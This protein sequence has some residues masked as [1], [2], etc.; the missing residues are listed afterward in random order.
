MGASQ[1]RCCGTLTDK[2]HQF[3]LASE[4]RQLYTACDAEAVG[5]DQ[6]P[7]PPD[8]IMPPQS[9]AYTTADGMLAGS[10]RPHA[11][12]ACC[13]HGSVDERFMPDSSARKEGREWVKPTQKPLE[14]LSDE[15]PCTELIVDLTKP[16][17]DLDLGL[18]VLH[19][20]V[21][22]LVV[23]EIYPGGAVEAANICNA[24][25]GAEVLEVGDQIAMVNGIGGD[26]AAIA[27]ECKRAMHLTLGVRRMQCQT[28][29]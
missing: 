17:P 8:L 26:D 12:W 25:A 6:L 9:Q 19:R 28:V 29:T 13:A 24:M 3:K 2:Q 1:M 22:V 4:D 15:G 20:G 10:P 7:G 18:R 11:T 16:R 14:N 21:G 5:N 27:E 23:A